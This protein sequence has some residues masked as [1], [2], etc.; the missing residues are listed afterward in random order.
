MFLLLIFLESL[1]CATQNFWISQA[2]KQE[3]AKSAEAG[4]K[5]SDPTNVHFNLERLCDTCCKCVQP[6]YHSHGRYLCHDCMLSIIDSNTPLLEYLCKGCMHLLSYP[7]IV[8]SIVERSMRSTGPFAEPE[9]LSMASVNPP[10]KLDDVPAESGSQS[11]ALD[12]LFTDPDSPAHSGRKTRILVT[13]I[14][15]NIV[16]PETMETF[17][18]SLRLE[19]ADLWRFSNYL[20]RC[21]LPE[22]FSDMMKI[23]DRI[24]TGLRSSPIRIADLNGSIDQ[25]RS[26]L[27]QVSLMLGRVP[28]DCKDYVK[29]VIRMC[30]IE[31]SHGGRR[32]TQST[33]QFIYSLIMP[34]M[35]RMGA[36]DLLEISSVLR[37]TV[38]RAD[39]FDNPIL[40]YVLD[41]L[42][43]DNRMTG[44]NTI[45]GRF[46][47]LE[48]GKARIKATQWKLVRMVFTDKYTNGKNDF[49]FCREYMLTG[50]YTRSLGALCNWILSIIK[51]SSV[52][53]VAS[54]EGRLGLVMKGLYGRLDKTM[55]TTAE[56]ANF[57]E[58]CGRTEC[59]KSLQEKINGDLSSLLRKETL[60]NAINSVN[61]D[62]LIDKDYIYDHIFS[63]KKTAGNND[64]FRKFIYSLSNSNMANSSIWVFHKLLEHDIVGPRHRKLFL[65]EFLIYL[66]NS[67]AKTLSFHITYMRGYCIEILREYNETGTLD[68]VFEYV[69]IYK[70]CFEKFSRKLETIWETE[71]IPSVTHFY[72]FNCYLRS[73]LLEEKMISKDECCLPEPTAS[74]NS[75]VWQ[76]MLTS[77]WHSPFPWLS[78]IISKSF[79]LIFKDT[80][81]E[82]FKEMGAI[83]NELRISRAQNIPELKLR[84]IKKTRNRFLQ[85]VSNSCSKLMQNGYFPREIYRSHLYRNNRACMI[86]LFAYLKRMCFIRAK[87]NGWDYR[88]ASWS[89]VNDGTLNFLEEDTGDPE[90]YK[91]IADI[92]SSYHSKLTERPKEEKKTWE[93]KKLL[94]SLVDE[95][96]Q[97]LFHRGMAYNDGGVRIK[98]NTFIIEFMSQYMWTRYGKKIQSF[99]WRQLDRDDINPE[100]LAMVT[101]YL[102]HFPAILTRSELLYGVILSS[103]N[104]LPETTAIQT[105]IP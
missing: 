87:I 85:S 63:S 30:K 22:S 26:F 66:N 78:T 79:D 74:L 51:N 94:L 44:N 60:S 91:A 58:I 12:D 32:V 38:K 33:Q 14:M 92:V 67:N 34:V 1:L 76:I 47:D 46:D 3:I 56:M 77:L 11:Q 55:Q 88:T 99:D 25:K 21:S 64:N 31:L 90:L 103:D 37:S 19:I 24:I 93:L 105:F 65:K 17:I 62:L 27:Y 23:I 71:L 53:K 18:Y 104:V 80:V 54:S 39:D 36:M 35:D 73:I 84:E 16:T 50:D 13:K 75:R 89:K 5:P 59:L 42:W 97:A 72:A 52:E 6:T 43:S 82:G 7:A 8:R 96:S 10:E 86:L 69:E 70:E 41:Y 101:S 28:A 9:N 4:P 68:N 57:Y 20:R 45:G 83:E 100:D 102:D 61:F 98:V 2:R 95:I 29:N 81:N 15:S 49:N 48:A 40:N